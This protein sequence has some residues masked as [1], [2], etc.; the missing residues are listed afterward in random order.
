MTERKP[1]GVD[2]ETWADR[3]IREAAE[4]GEFDDLPGMGEPLPDLDKP[5]DDLWWVRRKMRRE[6][7]SWLPPA[8]AL[9]KEAED[10]LA[11]AR[12]ARSEPEVRRILAEVDDRIRA[13]LRMPPPGPPLGLKP[14]DVE[15]V[16]R[17]WRRGRSA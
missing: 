5:Y 3:Q 16:V 8:L 6:G 13:A 12:G 15:E 7:L 11:A 1:P 4:R 14:F 17:E 9:R 10:A 2:F